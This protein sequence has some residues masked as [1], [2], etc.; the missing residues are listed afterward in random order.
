[1][2]DPLV[3]GFDSLVDPVL[4]FTFDPGHSS[5]AGNKLDPFRE[6]PLGGEVI[7]I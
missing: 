4:N 2:V 7:Y 1:M 3:P 5:A 6:N